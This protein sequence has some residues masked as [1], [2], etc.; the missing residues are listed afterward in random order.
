MCCCPFSPNSA[1]E[2]LSNE[3]VL[4]ALSW[5][6]LKLRTLNGGFN[7]DENGVTIKNLKGDTVFSANYKGDLSITGKVTAATGKIGGWT[8]H[9]GKLTAGTE[10]SGVAMIQAPSTTIGNVL[11]IGN[12]TYNTDGSVND[13]STCAFRVTKAGKLYATGADITGAITATSGS[14]TGKVTAT[15]GEIGGWTIGET[16]LKSKDG[17]ITLRSSSTK[18]V[19]NAIYVNDGA[20]YVRN[21][22]YIYGRSGTIGG[23][24]LANGY[25]YAGNIPNNSSTSAPTND[26]FAIYDDGAMIASKGYIG[27]WT[28]NANGLSHKFIDLNGNTS[29]DIFYIQKSGDVCFRQME[30]YLTGEATFSEKFLSFKWHSVDSSDLMG[31]GYAQIAS[32][33]T[34]YFHTPSVQIPNLSATTVEATSIATEDFSQSSD[35]RLKNTIEPLSNKYLSL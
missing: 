34:I 11:A 9:S 15:S 33:S 35:L 23:V 26:C 17:K 1:S 6:G 21:N 12:A 29:S 18:D 7:V 16:T 32:G 22:G 13:Y 30:L 4:F 5:A 24:T 2:V 14:F 31:H 19:F 27:G 20:F 8:I 25:V 28:I 3:N 10:A